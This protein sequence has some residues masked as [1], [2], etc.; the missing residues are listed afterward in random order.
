[1]F[2]ERF[3]GSAAH[4]ANRLLLAFANSVMPLGAIRDEWSFIE[5]ETLRSNIASAL[6]KVHFDILFVNQYN[7]YY[8]P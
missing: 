8:S 7:V 4:G 6:Q 2:A 1:L 5:N 3:Q